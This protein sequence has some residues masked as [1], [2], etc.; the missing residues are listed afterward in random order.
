MSPVKH[1]V[2][3]QESASKKRGRKYIVEAF[4]GTKF[5]DDF[6]PLVEVKY[7]DFDDAEWE[8]FSHMKQ[9]IGEKMFRKFIND[10]K[11]CA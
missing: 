3:F 4:L 7:E 11:E 2:L 6:E 1:C 9:E 5:S 8:T 10:M